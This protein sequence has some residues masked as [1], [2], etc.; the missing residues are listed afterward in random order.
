MRLEA[1]RSFLCWYADPSPL[2]SLFRTSSLLLRTVSTTPTLEPSTEFA[3]R[4]FSGCLSS[5]KP[6]ND[7]EAH[8]LTLATSLAFFVSPF[9]CSVGCQPRC[10]R[11]RCL[12]GIRGVDHGTS[13]GAYDPT[14][15][16]ICDGKKKK[17]KSI[18][19]FSSSPKH[20]LGR[21]F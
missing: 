9:P 4:P 18:P 10:W 15:A 7:G 13:R 11:R 3:V 12:Y 17:V 21:K 8:F 6:I 5:M 16:S 20:K 2:F 14:W 19:F 1:H